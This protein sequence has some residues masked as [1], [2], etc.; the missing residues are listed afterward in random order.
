M[1]SIGVALI[2][3]GLGGKVF[4]APIIRSVEGLR[5]AAV[6][7]SR[8][9]QVRADLGTVS[10]VP[11]ADAVF[12]DPAIGLVSIATPNTSHFD[13]VRRALLA[14]KH[15]VVDKPFTLTVAEAEVLA[16][17]AE[18]TGLLLAIYQSRRWDSDFLTLRQVIAS[19][20]LG[21]IVH[22]ESHYD[23]FRPVVVSRWKD[24]AGP[25]SGIWYDLGPHVAD[26]ALQL[27]GPPESVF[28][29]LA[30]QRDGAQAT[31]YF[32]VLL[33]Y[34][35]RRV[36]LH[37]STLVA[38]PPRRF[39]VHG[40]RG[41]YVKNGMDIQEDLLKAGDLPG[42]PGWGTDP[43]TGILTTWN[44]GSRHQRSIPNLPG[45]YPQFYEAV[46]DAILKGA[47]NPVPPEDGIAVMRVIEAGLQSAAA[48]SAVGY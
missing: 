46:R 34:P 39:E 26:Q 1:K 40:K 8:V 11:S 41:S 3:Y 28:A 29:D 14:G 9:E 24:N 21:E 15:V 36:V 13:L 4:H 32:H 44:G 10:V 30:M 25:G 18:R 38:E 45:G 12:S 20:E 2:G 48:G 31:D 27:F 6:V 35:A 33:K 17:E 42:T 37:G 23:R 22:F 7:T 16:E 19:G 47:P 43:N 5:L